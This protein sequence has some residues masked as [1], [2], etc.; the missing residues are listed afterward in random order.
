MKKIFTL[1]YTWTGG[2]Y[3]L[4]IGLEDSSEENL[5]KALKVLWTHQALE[6]CYKAQEIEP[7]EQDRLDPSINIL[8]VEGQLYGIAHLPN[9]K[10]VACYSYIVVYDDIPSIFS[11]SIS[12]EALVTAY[13]A[14]KFPF[15]GWSFQTRYEID[16]WF[17]QIS[18]RLFNEIGF[19]YGV[20]GQE[21]FE[22]ETNEIQKNGVPEQRGI[23]YLW[24]EGNIIKWYPPNTHPIGYGW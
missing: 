9:G 6:G 13:P 17:Y 3:E 16:E 8:P 1:P 21:V 18:T 11:L 14:R 19:P 7:F 2:S 15:T 23:S 20:I 4:E 24:H 12:L 5:Q 22:L 10:K